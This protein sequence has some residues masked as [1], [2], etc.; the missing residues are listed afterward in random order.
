MIYERYFL[1]FR[2]NEIL[3]KCG[4][5]QNCLLLRNLI[6][7]WKQIQIATLTSFQWSGHSRVFLWRE[8]WFHRKRRTLNPGG[9]AEDCF[10]PAWTY[11]CMKNVFFFS[12]I[13]TLTLAV[14]VMAAICFWF[15]GLLFAIIDN[16]SI[17]FADLLAITVTI[18]I[19]S[20]IAM[21]LLLAINDNTMSMDVL[22]VAIFFNFFNIYLLS[23]N[24]KNVSTSC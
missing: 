21:A 15:Y 5:I 10:Y 20:T 23:S 13:E 1:Y 16:T 3:S 19:A 8:T 2:C 24:V 7:C 17:A 18:T 12:S 6:G 22:L 9:I 14:L 4:Q 11:M